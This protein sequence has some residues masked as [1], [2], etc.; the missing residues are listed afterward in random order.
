MC[1]QPV[2][3]VVG[4]ARIERLDRDERGDHQP[5]LGRVEHSPYSP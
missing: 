3:R 4:L 5:E 2:R 1:L